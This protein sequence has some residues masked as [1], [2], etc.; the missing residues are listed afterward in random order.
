VTEDLEEDEGEGI[1]SGIL[2]LAFGLMA[3][4][5]FLSLTQGLDFV[6]FLLAFVGFSSFIIYSMSQ[7]GLTSGVAFG[8]GLITISFIGFN[9]WLGSLASVAIT[10][11]LWRNAILDYGSSDLAE[12]LP[13]AQPTD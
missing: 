6:V 10:V 1:G 13:P 7:M 9:T 5:F 8:F 3:P 11:N 2:S 12:D 4:V